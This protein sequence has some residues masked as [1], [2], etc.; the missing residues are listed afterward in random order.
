MNLAIFVE[1]GPGAFIGVKGVCEVRFVIGQS[2]I[3]VEQGPGAVIGV[4]AVRTCRH[5]KAS[6][7]VQMR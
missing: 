2:D 3:F 1:Q 6:L 4:D 7:R 5:E